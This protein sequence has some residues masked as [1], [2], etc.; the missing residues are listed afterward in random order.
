MNPNGQPPEPPDLRFFEENQ[1]KFPPEELIPYAGQ[2]VAWSPDGTRILASGSD[3]DEVDQKL[4]A[5]GIQFS[6]VVHDY[7]DPPPRMSLR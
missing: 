3:L 2:Q 6:Q 4:A 7:I 1:R 5:M